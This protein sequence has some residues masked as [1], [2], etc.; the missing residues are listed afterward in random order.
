M[1]EPTVDASF[2]QTA[3]HVHE[4]GKQ[5]PECDKLTTVKGPTVAAV[6]DDYF[7][8]ML[9]PPPDGPEEQAATIDTHR[10]TL[11]DLTELREQISVEKAALARPVSPAILEHRIQ[12]LEKE[13][14]AAERVAADMKICLLAAERERDTAR[15][16]VRGFEKIV[17]NF[18]EHIDALTACIDRFEADQAPT[19]DG[20][21]SDGE[22]C[23]LCRST[24][25]PPAPPATDGEND[26]GEPT[27]AERAAANV[28]G[29]GG[30]C[31]AGEPCP[32]AYNKSRARAAK[33]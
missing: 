10:P 32:M 4:R 14:R 19:S 6:L 25:C 3:M 7:V 9:A 26:A 13:K 15:E 23:P 5:C 20:R 11:P 21:S 2:D 29:C 18:A 28:C 16:R 17:A 31:D 22:V 8:F 30:L 1:A 27:P 24:D 12:I 33:L